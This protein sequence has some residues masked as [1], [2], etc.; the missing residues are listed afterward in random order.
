MQVCPYLLCPDAP[1]YITIANGVSV[2][3]IENSVGFHATSIVRKER[4][5]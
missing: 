5:A 3:Q 2:S 1:S 4:V